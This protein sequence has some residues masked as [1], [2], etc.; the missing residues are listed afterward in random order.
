MK[1]R[2]IVN[3][4]L[5]LGIVVLGLI[6][7]FEPGIKPPVLTPAITALKADDVH[8]IHIN[9]PVRDDLVL[10]RQSSRN[11]EIERAVPLPADDFKVRALTRLV[12][13]QPLR[14]YAADDMDLAALQLA[15][16][17][18]TAIFNETAI[19]FGSLEP[20]DSLRYV[21]VRD[22][23]YLIPDN[24]LPLLETGFTQFVRLRL[25]DDK[26]RIASVRIPDLAITRTGSE[27]TVDPQQSVSADVIQQFIDIWQDASAISIQP[28]DPGQSGEEVTIGLRDRAEPVMLQVISRQPE[29]VLSRPAW[30][31]QYRMGNRSE[32]L[33]T[34]DA[35][36]AD[37][38]D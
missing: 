17:Y 21:R 30:G 27:W 11:W 31:I 25:F 3:L 9:R 1:S 29:L 32:A 24:Y 34:L 19:E 7:R 18:A 36:S 22:H 5:L 20:I 12:E 28:A 33:L 37:V 4:L 35:A 2:M 23:V 10:Q 8:R 6:A 13:Q 38:A 15:P 16:P 14:S 26:A